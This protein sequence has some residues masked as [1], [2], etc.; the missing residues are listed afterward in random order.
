MQILVLTHPGSGWD[1]WRERPPWTAGSFCEGGRPAGM[2]GVWAAELGEY[3]GTVYQH[4]AEERQE[5]L[6]MKCPVRNKQRF[7]LLLLYS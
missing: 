1:R 6:S 7:H 3:T 2:G 4:Q 5:M